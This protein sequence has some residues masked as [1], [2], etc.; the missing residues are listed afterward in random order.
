MAI[1][2]GYDDQGQKTFY[3][4]QT[5]TGPAVVTMPDSGGYWNG[6]GFRL[7][8]ALRPNESLYVPEMD[9]S[10]TL[11][12]GLGSPNVAAAVNLLKSNNVEG[13]R[14]N[15][16]SNADGV[17]TVGNGLTLVVKGSNGWTVLPSNQIKDLLRD[18]GLPES[19]YDDLPLDKLTHSASL[20]NAGNKDAA[21]NV[22]G[23]GETGGFSVTAAEA[24]KLSAAYIESR[25]SGD[26][27]ARVR[28]LENARNFL[29]GQAL[30]SWLDLLFAG[31]YLAVMFYYSV[32]LT[33]VVLAALPV[34]FGASALKL[35]AAAG[36]LQ[37]SDLQ[38]LQTLITPAEVTQP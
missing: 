8:A 24:D 10:G 23:S 31:V 11:G 29:T 13:Y 32:T 36:Q 6:G 9:L 15:I 22:F 17:P 20:L 34:F 3:G 1:F 33:L 14:A 27:V 2:A 12:A 16:Y 21:K 30:T 4:S 19:K 37:E 25:R 38:N 18:A 35:L 7:A 5:S 28:E 26:T